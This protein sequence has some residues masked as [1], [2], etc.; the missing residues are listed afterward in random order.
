[1][2]EPPP[3]NSQTEVTNTELPIETGTAPAD[4]SR[5]QQ[6]RTVPSLASWGF[7]LLFP[8]CCAGCG[9]PVVDRDTLCPECW[10]D[11]EFIV[12]P[13]C[14]RLGI[15]LPFATGNEM[16]SA[17]AAARPPLYARARAVGHYDGPLRRLVHALK[18][19]DRQDVRHILATWLCRAGH[20][21]I[22][23]ADLI[24]P[25]P[26]YRRRL[27]TRRYN[28][29]ALLAAEVYRLTG[30]RSYPLALDR[31]R[32]TKSQVGLTA[33]QRQQNVRGAFKVPTRYARLIEGRR[34]LLVDDVITTGATVEACTRALL[35]NKA[36]NVDVLAVA[37]VADPL[38]V[39]T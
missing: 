36:K 19:H 39:T 30:I 35:D 23:D 31:T 7:D 37:L 22:T 11:I 4:K 13:L 14:N 2:T 26:L 34:V 29:S 15:R 33:K 24:I 18:F 3:P 38:R 10:K 8:P 32:K 6:A 17:A 25:V 1:M 21:L 27:L 12:P 5:P 16:V 28:Q 20:Q 9:E